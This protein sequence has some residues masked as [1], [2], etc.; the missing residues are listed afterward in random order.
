MADM[1][2]VEGRLDEG[3]SMLDEILLIDPAYGRAHNHLGW[4]YAAKLEKFD[5]AKEHF[6]LALKFS[7]DYPAVYL[8]LGRLYMQIGEFDKGIDLL[9]RGLNIPGIDKATVYDLLSGIYESRGEL[10][11]A[12]MNAKLAWKE[13]GNTEYMNYLKGSV[14]RIRAKKGAFLTLNFF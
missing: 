7:P 4:F 6:E 11:L 13:A 9:N 8:N 14:K 2:I 3:K 5:R 1:A 10:R 12:L